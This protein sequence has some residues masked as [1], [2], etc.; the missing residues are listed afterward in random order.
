M[1]TRCSFSRS[2]TFF[3]LLVVAVARYACICAPGELALFEARLGVE[4]LLS[5]HVMNIRHLD[6]QLSLLL[7]WLKYLQVSRMPLESHECAHKRHISNCRPPM[8]QSG[9]VLP[10]AHR[11]FGTPE[12]LLLILDTVCGWHLR[13]V[14]LVCKSWRSVALETILR[15]HFVSLGELMTCAGLLYRTESGWDVVRTGSVTLF[16]VSLTWS[17]G[18]CWKVLDDYVWSALS[19][20][21]SRLVWCWTLFPR[22]LGSHLLLSDPRGRERR[23]G[24]DI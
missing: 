15:F 3:F 12:L 2:F 1:H 17:L 24:K 8:P 4:R 9:P 10:V 18:R 6:L 11:V 7:G 19:S 20:H 13:K 5:S 14:A 23:R 21:L 16:N 22:L